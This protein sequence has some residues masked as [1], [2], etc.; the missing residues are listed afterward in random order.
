MEPRDGRKFL[1]LQWVAGWHA[2]ES[3]ASPLVIGSY[4]VVGGIFFALYGVV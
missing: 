4:W 3:Q 1:N 2:N